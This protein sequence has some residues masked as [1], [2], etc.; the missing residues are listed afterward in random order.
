MP[1]FFTKAVKYAILKENVKN[2]RVKGDVC[3][4]LVKERDTLI[5]EWLLEAKKAIEEMTGEVMQKS[6]NFNNVWLYK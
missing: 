1:I 4:S 5:K 3:M 6:I 2:H